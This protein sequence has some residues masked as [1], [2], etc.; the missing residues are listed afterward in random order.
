MASS[1]VFSLLN[2]DLL[3]DDVVVHRLTIIH[4]LVYQLDSFTFLSG[5]EKSSSPIYLDEGLWSTLM[6]SLEML[7]ETDAKAGH[8]SHTSRISYPFWKIYGANLD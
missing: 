1:F 7:L 4:L 6:F 2:T 5:L 8:I 3:F